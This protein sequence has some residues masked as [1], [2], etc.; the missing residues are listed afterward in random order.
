MTVYSGYIDR[1]DTVC[2]IVDDG[3][4]G[5]SCRKPA[6]PLGLQLGVMCIG[7]VRLLENDAISRLGTATTVEFN[8]VRKSARGMTFGDSTAFYYILHIASQT[9]PVVSYSHQKNLFGPVYL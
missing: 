9:P 2:A 6:K 5:E 8:Q 1:S 3:I 7:I 4:Y